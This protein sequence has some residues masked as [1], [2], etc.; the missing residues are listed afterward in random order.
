MREWAVELQHFLV[1]G[2][3]DTQGTTAGGERLR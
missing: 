1:S 3:T 2:S